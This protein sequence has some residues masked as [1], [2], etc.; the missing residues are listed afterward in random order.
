[1]DKLIGHVLKSNKDAA[2]IKSFLGDGSY[3]NNNNFKYLEL[4][5]IQPA[6]QDKKEFYHFV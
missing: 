6:N 2:K 5:K 4:K 1:M 3:D